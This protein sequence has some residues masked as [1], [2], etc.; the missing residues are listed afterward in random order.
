MLAV[1]FSINRCYLPDQNGERNE[2]ACIY[3]DV[4]PEVR[5]VKVVVDSKI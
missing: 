2:E 1:E 3:A 5:I 4:T